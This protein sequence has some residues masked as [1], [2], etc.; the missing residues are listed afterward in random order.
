MKKFI[1]KYPVIFG[2]LC[3]LIGMPAV[4]AIT[5]WYP[6]VPN[7]LSEHKRLAEGSVFTVSEF[8]VWTSKLWELRRKWTFAAV[9]ACFFALH[10]AGVVLYSTQ[11]GP[12]L[13]WQ[14]FFLVLLEFQ[15]F[16]YVF[17]WLTERYCVSQ[18]S[19]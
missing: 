1:T 5:T 4:L 18:R 12:I 7:Y 14:W 16:G 9:T 19:R 6:S 13:V 10:V 8:V 15:V 2:V 11:V 17:A 3:A